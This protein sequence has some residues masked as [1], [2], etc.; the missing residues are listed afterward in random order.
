MQLKDYSE[1]NMVSLSDFMMMDDAEA[2]QF[3]FLTQGMEP[4]RAG[5]I[6]S[7]YHRVFPWFDESREAGDT[8]STYRTA[9]KRFYGHNYRYLSRSQQLAVISI[10]E[11]WTPHDDGQIFEYESVDK[12]G[13]VYYQLCNNYQLGN[14]G[15]MP[16]GG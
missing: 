16:M 5:L 9:V 10:I 11:R 1:R 14:F 3:D 13:C 12:K 15:I 7:I 2:L 6:N 4:D 8:L